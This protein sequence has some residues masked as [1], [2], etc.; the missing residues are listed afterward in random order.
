M[1][2]SLR[3]VMALL[4]PLAITM[5]LIAAS[6]AAARVVDCHL[7]ASETQIITSARNMTC[8]AAARDVHRTRGSISYSYAT[9]GG[10]RCTR[11]SGDRLGGE[12]RCVRGAR[13][14]RFEFGD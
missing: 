5:S 9:A 7:T 14:Y 4:V 6:T 1:R 11:V 8:A 12:W 10:F 3:T 13:A 2:V